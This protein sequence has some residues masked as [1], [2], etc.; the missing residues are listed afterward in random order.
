MHGYL[1][2]MTIHLQHQGLL[3]E[4]GKGGPVKSWAWAPKVDFSPSN[5]IPLKVPE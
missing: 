1:K 3:E 2:K 5:K 4:G